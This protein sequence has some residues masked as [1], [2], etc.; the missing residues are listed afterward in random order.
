MK[1]ITI[2][3]A[4]VVVAVAAGALFAS[5][6]YA[7]AP[8]ADL[9]GAPL[10]ASLAPVQM[11]SATVS[12]LLAKELAVLTNQGISPARAWQAIDVQG[13]VARADLPER[14]QTSLAR[15]YAGVWFAPAT[16]Q[17]HVGVTSPASR[18]AAE[19]IA[20]RAGLTSEVAFTPVRS[21]VA[22][23]LVTQRRWNR[24]LAKLFARE[25]V[26]TG[27]ELRRNA[28]SI[29]LTSSVPSRQLAAIKR[30]AASA[31]VNVFVSVVPGPRIG[32]SDAKECSNFPEANCN[33]SITAGVLIWTKLKCSKVAN[34]KGS[35]FFKT[36]KEC[37]EEKATGSEGEWK[38]AEATTEKEEEEGTNPYKCTAGPAAIPR[39][40]KKARVLL[41]AGHCIESGGGENVEWLAFT[42]ELAEPTIGKARKFV[43]GGLGE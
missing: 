22:Q 12:P 16:A 1:R 8:D 33:P 23:L 28:V 34:T 37:E 39:A 31:S 32:F 18:H 38:R 27:L 7:S 15:A 9:G 10:A 26:E 3:L 6:A 25:A 40:T 4:S 36:Q 41:T 11:T 13:K 20:A 35:L 5:A 42:R 2:A 43:N 24:K 14:L 29:T 17:L 19:G 21:T 30:E